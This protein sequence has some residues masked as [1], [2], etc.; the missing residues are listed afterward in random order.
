VA[1]FTFSLIL[2]RRMICVDEGRD[3]G[4]RWKG[5]EGEDGGFA[6]DELGTRTVSATSR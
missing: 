5:K 3:G 4:S 6:V 2:K 1:S